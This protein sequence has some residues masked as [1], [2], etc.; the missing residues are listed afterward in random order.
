MKAYSLFFVF[1]LALSSSLLSSCD[2]TGNEGQQ[3]SDDWSIPIDEVRDGGPGKDGIPALLN[4]EMI[5]PSDANYLLDDDL[6]IGYAY[7]GEAKAYSHKVLDWHEII[8][9]DIGGKQLAITYCPL[10]GTGIGWDRMHNGEVTTFGVSGLLY[11]TNLIPYDRATDSNWTQIG[12]DC[13]NGGRIGESIATYQLI[14]TTWSTWLTLYPETQVVSTNTG[15]SRNYERYPYGDYRTNENLIFP[16]STNDDER[17]DPK[18]RVYGVISGERVKVYEFHHF[19]EQPIIED[20]FDAKNIVLIGS[21]VQNFIV[22]FYQKTINDEILV[23]TVLD[24][25]D[26][27]Q[28]FSSSTLM[29]DQ[30]GNEWDVFG[31]AISGPNQGET[32]EATQ[33]FIGYWFSWGAFYEDPDI[34]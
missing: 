17:L 22:S 10:T 34:Y 2:N 29:K 25:F 23:F 16:I 1:G 5:S 27:S 12:L 30:F 20:S 3:Q 21:D 8:N 33:S 9:D 13:V 31:H 11:N 26:I 32:L 15:H 28:G 6:V 4:P 19:E 14:E 7:N 24:D 18:A